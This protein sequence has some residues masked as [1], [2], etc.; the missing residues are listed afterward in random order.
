[1]PEWVKKAQLIIKAQ[2][3]STPATRS[4]SCAQ[5]GHTYKRSSLEAH[6]LHY[7]ECVDLRQS[8]WELAHLP[9]M[10]LTDSV[11][12]MAP[13]EE[14]QEVLRKGGGLCKGSSPDLSHT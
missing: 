3:R 7:N 1:M 2:K 11:E 13:R 10:T 14:S 6:M 8:F 12:G 4:F 5:C 9:L